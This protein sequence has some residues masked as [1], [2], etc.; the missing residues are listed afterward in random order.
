VAMFSIGGDRRRG[1]YGFKKPNRTLRRKRRGE[2]FLGTV[3]A[4]TLT[5]QNPILFHN[6][7][8]GI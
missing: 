5:E 7:I 4:C 8:A 3:E 2:S 1:K 6:I